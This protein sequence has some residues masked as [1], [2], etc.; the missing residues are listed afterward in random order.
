M[1]DE[2]K[3]VE[4]KHGKSGWNG[5][6][7]SLDV[8]DYDIAEWLKNAINRHDIQTHPYVEFIFK[9]KHRIYKVTSGNRSHSITIQYKE[10][11][12]K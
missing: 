6:N 5:V 1:P 7:V 3:Q 10:R 8:E 4:L 11:Q 12:K 2:W 9:G